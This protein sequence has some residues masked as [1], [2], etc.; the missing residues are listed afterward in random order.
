MMLI[1]AT[2]SIPAGTEL[3]Q[4]YS[5][6]DEDFTV[7][8]EFFQSHWGFECDCVLCTTESQ[9][10]EPMHQK[11]RDLVAKIKVEVLKSPVNTRIPGATIK[12]I[13]RLTK[14]LEDFH[15]KSIYASLPRLLL[16]HPTIWLTEQYRS[17]RNPS[18]TLKYA[19][20]VLRNFGFV[21]A[22]KD[23]KL[24]LDY[25]KGI[26]NSESFN[27]L[28]YAA[29]AYLAVGKVELSGRCDEEARK[30]FAILTGSDVGVEEVF[31][32]LK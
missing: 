10:P 7:R 32:G 27:A 11:R 30:M 24:D 17:L 26:V 2:C 5:S 31:T 1:R 15:E 8:R 13:E 16:V 12:Y 3:V 6:P 19:F 14:K 9:S 20:E 18:K 28:R 23:G 4:Q 21:D 25:A 29:E 22:V